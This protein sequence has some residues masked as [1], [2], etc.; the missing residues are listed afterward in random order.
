MRRLRSASRPR[1]MVAV[2]FVI[3]IIPFMMIFTGVIQLALVS[4]A[5][6]TVHYAAACAARAAIVVVPDEE[7]LGHQAHNES[8][9]DAAVYAILPIAP[10]GNSIADA[11]GKGGGWSEASKNTGVIVSESRFGTDEYDAQ[12]TVRVVYAYHCTI[13]IAS[14]YFCGP[15]SD[16]PSAAQEDLHKANITPGDGRYLILRAQ[17][18]LTKQGRPHAEMNPRKII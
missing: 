14:R 4:V 7:E 17:H 1:G 2:E 18:T 12:I 9:R 5:K 11:F 3:A 13:P 15:I 10:Q 6:L 8:I 16:L